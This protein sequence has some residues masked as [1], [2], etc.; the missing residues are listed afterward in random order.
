[1]GANIRVPIDKMLPG[2]LCIGFNGTNPWLSG[3]VIILSSAMELDIVHDGKMYVGFFP[4]G[5]IKTFYVMTRLN[6]NSW[7]EVVR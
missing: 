1:M 3:P 2:D 6:E 5:D 7:A 4:D